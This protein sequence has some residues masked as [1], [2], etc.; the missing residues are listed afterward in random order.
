MKTR[1]DNKLRYGLCLHDLAVVSY[2]LDSPKLLL[3]HLFDISIYE[4]KYY[5]MDLLIDKYVIVPHRICSPLHD[6]Y[7]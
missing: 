2:L 5:A 1:G 7:R 6:T 3:E 4:Q